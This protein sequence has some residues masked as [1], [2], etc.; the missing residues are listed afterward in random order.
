MKKKIDSNKFTP[1]DLTPEQ[2]EKLLKQ[3]RQF[4]KPTRREEIINY[5]SDQLKMEEKKNIPNKS[6]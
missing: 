3:F 2:K 6:T 5:I 4:F 1:E